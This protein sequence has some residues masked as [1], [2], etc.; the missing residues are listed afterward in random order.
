MAIKKLAGNEPNNKNGFAFKTSHSKLQ[1]TGS[2]DLLSRRRQ[3]LGGRLLKRRGQPLAAPETSQIKKLFSNQ[4]LNSL[5][6][7]DFVRLSPYLETVSLASGEELNQAGESINYVY[8]PEDVTV[9]Q[10]QGFADGS[11]AEIIMVGNEGMIGLNAVFGSAPSPFWTQVMTAGKV[12]RIKTSVLKEEFLRNPSLQ[13]LLLNYANTYIAQISQRVS[14]NIRHVAEAR[15]CTWLLMLQ[16]R[17]ASECLRLTQEQIAVCL[18]INRPTVTNLAQALKESGIIDYVRGCIK[19]L[20]RRRLEMSACECYQA[21]K[22]YLQSS[23][24]H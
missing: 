16:D 17:T 19:I 6:D 22:E 14:C 18:G 1:T 13:F 3:P 24:V 11:T 4:L 2:R 9:S 5:T 20:D 21:T 15:F 8:F 23:S 10:F 7:S 12:F